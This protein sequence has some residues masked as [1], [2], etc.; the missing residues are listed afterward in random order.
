[1]IDYK[2][3][4]KS[5]EWQKRRLEILKRDKF[6]CQACGENNKELHI[7]HIKY[8]KNTNYWDY[9]DNLL[10]TLCDECHTAEHLCKDEWIPNTIKIINTSGF[11]YM[12]I[13]AVLQ[14]VFIDSILESDTIPNVLSS[15]FHGV[16]FSCYKNND[17]YGL[18]N[19][20]KS[21]NK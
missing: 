4:I 17:I 11:T 9:P 1:M 18:S 2:E 8:L 20:R 14:Y 3:Q 21:L 5:P 15:V 6:T 7:H 13:F 12:E 16:N 10:I 19:W